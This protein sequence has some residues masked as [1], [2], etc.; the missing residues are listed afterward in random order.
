MTAS[1]SID[2][3]FITGGSNLWIVSGGFRMDDGGASGII[4]LVKRRQSR[5]A[6]QSQPKQT[7]RLRLP[8]S[9][10]T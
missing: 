4:G 10:R 9:R 5:Y 8:R 1:D 7:K 6:C 2:D 3:I